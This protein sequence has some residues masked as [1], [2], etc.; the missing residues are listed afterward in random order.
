MRAVHAQRW[1]GDAAAY[2]VGGVALEEVEALGVGV[3]REE[4]V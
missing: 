1:G 2:F 4:G 3:V